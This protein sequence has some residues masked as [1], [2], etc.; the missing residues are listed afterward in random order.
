ME[1]NSRIRIGSS[2][3]ARLN[4]CGPK[5]QKH[6]SPGQSDAAKPQSAALGR[7]NTESSALKGRNK[8]STRR[9]A[10]VSPFQ[11]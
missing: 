9:A 7:P 11:G 4:S 10:H 5:G 6:I 2:L 3:Q 8:N 1:G